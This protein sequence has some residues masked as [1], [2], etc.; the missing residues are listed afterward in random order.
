MKMFHAQFLAPQNPT[1]AMTSCPGPQQMLLGSCW[2]ITMDPCIS[3]LSRVV[4]PPLPSHSRADLNEAGETPSSYYTGSP[5]PTFSPV[6]FLWLYFRSKQE[7]E[8]AECFPP[9]APKGPHSSIPY[10]QQREDSFLQSKWVWRGR[11]CAAS[12]LPA[13]L[14]SA[15]KRLGTELQRDSDLTAVRECAGSAVSAII[16]PSASRLLCLL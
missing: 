4:C 12:L 14:S 5:T 16:C 13:A 6:P 3:V 7:K 9:C 15:L 1:S 10:V 2:R 11:G 8:C